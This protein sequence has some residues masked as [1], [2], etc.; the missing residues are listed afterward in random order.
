MN[1]VLKLIKMC[2]SIVFFFLFFVFC[3][4]SR[5]LKLQGVSKWAQIN[6][7]IL[8]CVFESVMHFIQFCNIITEI[9]LFIQNALRIFQSSS[10]LIE[11]MKVCEY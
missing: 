4:S 9:L 11:Y 10:H 2:V 7:E 6:M 1:W 5:I 3:F 8:I